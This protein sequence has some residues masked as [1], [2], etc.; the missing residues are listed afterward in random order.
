MTWLER[1][2]IVLL[3]I[4]PVVWAAL[5]AGDRYFTDADSYFH[6]GVARRILEDG[7][8]RRFEW[9]PYTTLHDPFPDMHLAQHLLLVPL[10][11]IL[12]PTTALEV[13]TVLLSSAVALS[14]YLVLRRRGVRWAAPWVVLGLLA[15]PLALAYSVFLKGAALFLVLLPWF[16]DAVWEGRA[17]RVFALAWASV[18]V[19]VGAAVLVPFAIVHALVARDLRL[20]GATVAGLVVGMLLH[21]AWPAHWGHVAAELASI[22]ER[23]ATLIP[24]ELRGA[25]WAT[26]TGPTLL[27]IAGAALAAWFVVVVRRLGAVAPAPAPATSGAIAALGLL[28]GALLAGTK[29]VELFIVLSILTVP[30]LLAP[31]RWPR[32][33]AALAIAAATLVAGW[34]VREMHAQMH[35]PGLPHPRDYRTLATWLDVRAAPGEV[36]LA[37]WDDMPGLFYYGGDQRYAAGVNVQFLRDGDRIRFEAYALLY[38]G[39]IADP[40]R[41]LT[42][43]FDGAR[44]VL[45]RRVPHLPGEPALTARLVEHP[46]FE[47]LASPSS[48]WRVFRLVRPPSSRDD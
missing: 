25:E 34:T 8:L 1:R 7:W 12:D 11:A 40:D 32:G 28:G 9:L 44:L 29:L 37:P 48:V 42:E 22:V 2:Q 23:D 41:A 21:P 16:V 4:L 10:V 33:A 13:G 3:A 38:R 5:L 36:V 43:L 14:L 15:N 20:I 47:E 26:L 19:Y 30:Q 46:A 31:L 35:A 17:R 24:G 45:V 18:Y 39:V 6:V 27:V